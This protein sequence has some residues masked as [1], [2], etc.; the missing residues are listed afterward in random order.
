MH[1]LGVT[2]YARP[3]ELVL[4]LSSSCVCYAYGKME[5]L[6]AKNEMVRLALSSLGNDLISVQLLFLNA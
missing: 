5:Q 1:T 3:P 6:P 4:H 2:S